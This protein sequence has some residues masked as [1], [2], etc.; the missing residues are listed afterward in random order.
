MDFIDSKLEAFLQLLD[1]T[2]SINFELEDHY[3]LFKN[4]INSYDASLKNNYYFFIFIFSDD[5]N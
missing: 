4:Q 2:I 3:L 1:E 5:N